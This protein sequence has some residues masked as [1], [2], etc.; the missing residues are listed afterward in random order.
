MRGLCEPGDFT[1]EDWKEQAK[2]EY[3]VRYFLSETVPHL[4]AVKVTMN[5]EEFTYWVKSQTYRKYHRL[6]LRQPHS[7]TSD[8]YRWGWVDEDQQMLFACFNILV[9]YVDIINEA[10]YKTGTTKKDFEYL[11]E[12]IKTCKEE[13]RPMFQSQLDHLKEVKAL[14]DYWTINRKEKLHRIDV[15]RS[16]WHDNRIADKEKKDRTRWDA[17]NFAQKVFDDEESEAL[18]RLMKIR[19]CLWT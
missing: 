10:S 19:K 15:L 1:W 18:N 5:I 8:D 14:Y 4:W 16:E 13:E 6:D 2:E 11:D 17:L 9:S 7:G 12:E 3:P